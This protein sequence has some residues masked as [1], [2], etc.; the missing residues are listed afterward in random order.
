MTCSLSSAVDAGDPDLKPGFPVQCFIKAHDLSGHKFIAIGNVDLKPDLEIIVERRNV[1]GLIEVV[2][3]RSDGTTTRNLISSSTTLNNGLSIGE[4]SLQ[5]PG[6][7]VIADASLASGSIT[8]SSILRAGRFVD[9][10]SIGFPS[11]G[12]PAL[13]DFDGDGEMEI[14]HGVDIGARLYVRRANGAVMP[15]WPVTDTSVYGV[16]TVCVADI[17]LDGSPE[18]IVAARPNSTDRKLFAFRLDGSTVPG[19]PLSFS[20]PNYRTPIVVGNVDDDPQPEVVFLRPQG[21]SGSNASVLLIG[22]NGA[23][24][25]VIPLSSYQD[26][27]DIPCPALADIDAD[28]R[29]EII[30]QTEG[31]IDV[32]RGTGSSMPGWPVSYPGVV[33]RAVPIV[34]DIDGDGSPDICFSSSGFLTEIYAYSANGS[35][36][37]GFPKS[38]PDTTGIGLTKAT[39]A[40]ADLEGDGR[41]D[42]VVRRYAPVFDT[43]AFMDTV[44]AFDL[45]GPHYGPV[46]WGQFGGSPRHIFTYPVIP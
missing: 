28:G 25:R 20:S 26:G 31:K 42:L 45:K 15:G 16:S 14:V 12:I 13:F 22:P 10:F 4:L 29:A 18:I 44:W 35:L 1:L 27:D 9:Y 11:I 38:L 21:M 36:I 30:V 33:S 32:V 8:L 40:M 41:T 6:L 2:G 17:D 23:T 3:I 34:G 39:I 5:H 37:P 24:K 46:L 19:W 7:E 43:D